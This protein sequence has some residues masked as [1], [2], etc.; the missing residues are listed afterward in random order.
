[1]SS[2]FR[3]LRESRPPLDPNLLLHQDV[4]DKMMP[5]VQETQLPESCTLPCQRS[6]EIKSQI[7][8]Q[9]FTLTFC[10]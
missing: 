4:L 8:G 3:I 9:S 6:F 5:A 10:D 1:M 7:L 2:H